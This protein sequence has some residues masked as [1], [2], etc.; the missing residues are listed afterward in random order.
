M[1]SATT[2][3][4]L[5]RVQ[6]EGRLASAQR[7]HA[8]EK[9]RVDNLEHKL[10]GWNVFRSRMHS[11]D[12]EYSILQREGRFAQYYNQL[13]HEYEIKDRGSYNASLAEDVARQRVWADAWR[14]LYEQLKEM[15]G[16][17]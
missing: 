1:S 11:A 2:Q 15:H 6:L 4:H 16:A 13:I 12:V 7:I 17:E 14:R 10:M 9:E 3:A 8:E 5:V